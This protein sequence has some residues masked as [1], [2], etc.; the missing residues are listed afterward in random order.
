MRRSRVCRLATR[1]P[2]RC[3]GPSSGHGAA[4]C[5][6][7]TPA[8]LVARHG[9]AEADPS[10]ARREVADALA[11]C[12]AAAPATARSSPP[13]WRPCA[14]RAPAAAGSAAGWRGGARIARL[15]GRRKVEGSEIFGADAC[16][17][18]CLACAPSAARIPCRLRPRRSRGLCRR[19]AR[20]RRVITASDVPGRDRYGVIPPFADQPVFATARCASAARRSRRS[21]ASAAAVERLDLGDLPGRLGAAAAAHDDRRGARSRRA[22]DPCRPRRTMS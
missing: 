19:H 18:G 20:A 12:C 21:S 16:A 14:P 11:A 2:A 10:R 8:M 17:G 15:D 3:S 7:C 6:A 5:G 4:Q 22:A 9:P 13:C 1:R